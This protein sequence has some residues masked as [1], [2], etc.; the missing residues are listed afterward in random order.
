MTAREPASP[1]LVRRCHREE[2]LCRLRCLTRCF[3]PGI[4]WSAE[5]H[6][7]CV[8][9]AGGKIAAEF[10]IE[11]S[12]DGIAALIRRLAK[13]GVAGM[14]PVAIESGLHGT[15]EWRPYQ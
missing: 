14:M 4:D 12:A 3:S 10:V 9:N 13:H 15:L 6:A 8:M 11:H 2:F 7:V 5:T 1:P